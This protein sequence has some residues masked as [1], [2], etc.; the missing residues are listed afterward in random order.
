[1]T[2]ALP[3]LSSGVC[4]TA[5]AT[6]PP[7]AITAL[8]RLVPPT[9]R[10][11]THAFMRRRLT[12]PASG[13]HVALYD[14][15]FGGSDRLEAVVAAGRGHNGRLGVSQLECG[16][17]RHA[18]EAD[19]LPRDDA[20]HVNPLPVRRIRTGGGQLD[21]LH[22]VKHQAGFGEGQPPPTSALGEHTRPGE[23]MVA[24]PAGC[25]AEVDHLQRA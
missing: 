25:A 22:G 8:F 9:S 2:S 10:A 12:R 24:Y 19:T 3:A 16:A 1:M 17:V 20:Q 14:F 23:Q 5:L 6:C 13:R 4:S 18:H 15:H 7:G 11:T 21:L